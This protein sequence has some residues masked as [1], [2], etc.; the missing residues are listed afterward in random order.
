MLLVLD[1]GLCQQVGEEV[2]RCWAGDKWLVFVLN[3]TDV[4]VTD[5]EAAEDA[6]VP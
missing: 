2:R 4:R 5:P 3:K 1:A 6:K